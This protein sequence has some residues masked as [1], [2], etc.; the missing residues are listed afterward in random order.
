MTREDRVSVRLGPGAGAGEVNFVAGEK[1][2]LRLGPGETKDAWDNNGAPITRAEF[3]KVLAREQD[4][5]ERPVF[6][7]VE[8]AHTAAA[9]QAQDE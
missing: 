6:E 3:E 9:A 4:A 8:P 7:A 1:Y 5:E 2:A